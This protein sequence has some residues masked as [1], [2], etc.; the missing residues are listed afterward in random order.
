MIVK[1]RKSVKSI[2]FA[3]LTDVVTK[4]FNDMKIVFTLLLLFSSLINA[5]AQRCI[6]MSVPAAK[7]FFKVDGYNLSMRKT[8][9]ANGK[10]LM[11]WN[12]DAGSSETE[13][14]LFFEG[15]GGTRY[16][17][18]NL[19][20]AYTETV[21][22]DRGSLLPLIGDMGDWFE[23]EFTTPNSSKQAFVMKKFGEKVNAVECD[24][25]DF[26]P[27]ERSYGLNGA[28]TPVKNLPAVS[29]AEGRYAKLKFGVQKNDNYYDDGSFDVTMRIPFVVDGR[30]LTMFNIV[31]PVKADDTKASP[32]LY[33]GTETGMDDEEYVVAELRMKSVE[34]EMRVKAVT[35]ALLSISEADFD[36]LLENMLF[37]KDD[38]SVFEV[39]VRTDKGVYENWK[40]NYDVS[41]F[42]KITQKYEY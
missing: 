20:G 2:T 26:C 35:E 4:N 42:P 34:P 9:D 8:P 16:R 31:I 10:K 14:M 11:K 3:L 33:I 32:E 24:F 17:N 36:K 39:W 7:S 40:Y 28:V 23:V 5:D 12:S 29:R 22:P 41:G 25:A 19:T 38:D 37:S 30:Y 13:T 1:P 27:A 15:E 6:T 18:D 21:H